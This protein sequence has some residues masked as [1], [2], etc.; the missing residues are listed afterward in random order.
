ME[1]ITLTVVES[2]IKG[3]S[4]DLEYIKKNVD[5]ILEQ[6]KKT[7]GRVSGH[8]TEIAVLKTEIA[9]FQVQLAEMKV[10][11]VT[12]TADLKSQIGEN[13][14]NSEGV[15]NKIMELGWKF[16]FSIATGAGIVSWFIQ[17]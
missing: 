2:S 15:K 6:T 10:Q 13:V 11:L 12:N 1:Q 14:K 17:K 16:F 3:M 4:V 7:N 8:D 9:N 5:E